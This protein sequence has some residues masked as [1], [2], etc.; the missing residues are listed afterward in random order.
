[1][2]VLI[3]GAGLSGVCCAGVLPCCVGG[4]NIFYLLP[5]QGCEFENSG[6]SL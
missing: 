3:I 2:E 5:S 1:M 4:K 6:M